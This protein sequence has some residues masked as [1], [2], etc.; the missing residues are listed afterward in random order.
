MNTDKII[1]N[2]QNRK[3]ALLK[4][5]ELIK[6]GELVVFP[7]ET[8]YGLGAD[9]VNASAVKK[10]FEAKGRPSDN[11]LIVHIGVSE[12]LED[13]VE[14]VPPAARRL[15]EAYWP[16][17]LTMIFKKK[18]HIPSVVTANLD[19]VAIRLPKHDAAREL[20]MA[21]DTAIAAPSANRSGRPSPTRAEH[22]WEDLQGR[23]PLILDG[24]PCE[25][26]IESTV[27]DMTQKIPVIL[28]P[29][30]V[31]EAMIAAAIGKVVS[32]KAEEHRDDSQPVRSP[33][34]KYTHYA[35]AAPLL[36]FKGEARRVAQEIRQRAEAVVMEGRSP[37]IMT[38]SENAGLYTFEN[39]I[40]IGSKNN[41]RELEHNLFRALLEFDR[42][43]TDVI[44]AE[45]IE[46][47]E[48]GVAVMNRLVR[49][50]GNRIISL[51]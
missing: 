34:M 27:I 30:D 45:C 10:I 25:V 13:Y 17:P 48:Q 43:G 31:T 49:A 42:R 14:E 37:G 21:C 51:N 8:V 26:G 6:L 44:F 5:A 50:A 32:L 20:I 28:R 9:A 33:G 15:I 46:E 3:E 23:V 36:L 11:P 29:G 40:I 1:L 47:R 22:V 16:G 24:G 41:F 12:Q 38:F 7:T 19:T 4:A 35:P 39:V 18:K 2:K